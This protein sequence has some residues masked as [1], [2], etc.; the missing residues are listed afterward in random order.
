MKSDIDV[1]KSG[2]KHKTCLYLL[3]NSILILKTFQKTCIYI[4]AEKKNIR[5]SIFQFIGSQSIE[6]GI[7]ILIS[8]HL[9][10]YI[11]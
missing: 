6:Y 7:T 4:Y 8:G 1:M 9:D 3:N 11:Q 2:L 5:C 10:N